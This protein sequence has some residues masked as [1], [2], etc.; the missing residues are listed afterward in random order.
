MFALPI[1]RERWLGGR[2]VLA[3]AGIAV[4]ALAAGVFIWAGAAV[5]GADVALLRMLEAALNTLPVAVVFVGLAA[6]AYALVPR[7]S[8]AVAYGLVTVA[9]LWQLVGSLLGA[10]SWLVGLTPFAHVG[11]VPAQPFRVAAATLMVAI[12]VACAL[13]AQ[14]AFRRRDLLGA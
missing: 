14:G 5:A 1:G 9:Y 2:L 6:L 12:G 8:A 10:P 7:A 4:V 11:L 13:V 3:V